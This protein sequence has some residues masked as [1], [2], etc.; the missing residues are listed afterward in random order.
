MLLP[1][2]FG[3]KPS[4]ATKCWAPGGC[5]GWG[6]GGAQPHS[7]TSS[8]CALPAPFPGAFPSPPDLHA[9]H[10]LMVPMPRGQHGQRNQE[11][12]Q[13]SCSCGIREISHT[14]PSDTL[15]KRSA[16]VRALLFRFTSCWSLGC[17]RI[18][19]R[20]L[21]PCTDGCLSARSL[22]VP[23]AQ[24]H[25]LA[26]HHTLCSDTAPAALTPC[27]SWSSLCSCLHYTVSL[28]TSPKEHACTLVQ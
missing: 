17:V 5:M 20:G 10:A 9:S 21:Q 11:K 24:P 26:L 19:K 13:L 18:G 7:V 14:F 6:G 28:S 25:L 23:P 22:S 8:F 2:G 16:A 4:T 12:L 1:N 3:S 27:S 15:F